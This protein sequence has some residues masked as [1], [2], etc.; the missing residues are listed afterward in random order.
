[1]AAETLWRY[2][3]GRHLWQVPNSIPDRISGTAQWTR[4]LKEQQFVVKP[5]A[6]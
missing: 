6:Y 5:S 1:M 4:L 3:G 2:I